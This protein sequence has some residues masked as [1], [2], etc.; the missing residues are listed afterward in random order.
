MK[1]SVRCSPPA[2]IHATTLWEVF[3][4]PAPLGSPFLQRLTHVRV[5]QKKTNIHI[6]NGNIL[7]EYIKKESAV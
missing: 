2:H 6:Y 7:F 4:V 1:T 5:R 3:H